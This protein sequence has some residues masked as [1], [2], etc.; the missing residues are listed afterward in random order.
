MSSQSRWKATV[1]DALGKSAVIE[2][3]D[4]K[5]SAAEQEDQDQYKLF[6]TPPDRKRVRTRVRSGSVAY[7]R[8][9]DAEQMAAR[10][11]ILKK[12]VLPLPILTLWAPRESF[13][14]MDVAK[15]KVMLCINLVGWQEMTVHDRA[16]Y[17]NVLEMEKAL[18]KEKLEEKSPWKLSGSVTGRMSTS[19]PNLQPLIN[20]RKSL[21]PGPQRDAVKNL[22]FAFAYGSD[23]A[24]LISA[25]KKP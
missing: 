1:R 2:S 18:E 6:Y 12:G 20:L 15:R 5:I 25:L 7:V 21:P 17:Y 8:L 10:A 11:V 13:F 24:Q 22:T 23:P 4:L 16:D 14:W 19:S 9:E 3:H